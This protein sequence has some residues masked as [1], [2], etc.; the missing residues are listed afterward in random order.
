[1][2]IKIFRIYVDCY[3]PKENFRKIVQKINPYESLVLRKQFLG[4]PLFIFFFNVQYLQMLNQKNSG[5]LD[6]NPHPGGWGRI[7]LPK[8]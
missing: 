8:L 1:M 2:R 5:H 4:G 6:I 3:D 7:R